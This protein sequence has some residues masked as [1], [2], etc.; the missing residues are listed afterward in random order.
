MKTINTQFQQNT[1]EDL[2]KNYLNETKESYK[3]KTLEILNNKN[4]TFSEMINT[5]SDETDLAR[6]LNAKKFKRENLFKQLS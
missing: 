4:V 1:V 3:S 6:L 5:Q 2:N